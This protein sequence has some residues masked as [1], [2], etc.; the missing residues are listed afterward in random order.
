LTAGLDDGDA[1]AEA[2]EHL[3]ELEAH[4]TPSENQE[5]FGDGVEFHDRGAV[6]KG[7]ILQAFKS[8]RGGAAAGVDEDA[9]SRQ[10]PVAAVFQTNGE[11]LRRR[12]AGF[13][14]NNVEVLGFF[15]ASLAAV[16]E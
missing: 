16:A 1:A 3:P 7:R 8:R 6:E 14:E 11:R 12:E 15:Q 13:T 4:V 5:V 2:A 10:G 9:I